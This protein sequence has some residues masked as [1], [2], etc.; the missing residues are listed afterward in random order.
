MSSHQGRGSNSTS[1][2]QM[3]L[4]VDGPAL[5][6]SSPCHCPLCH[7]PCCLKDS[8]R[9]H[10]RQMPSCQWRGWRL[11]G[12]LGLINKNV[13]KGKEAWGLFYKEDGLSPRKGRSLAGE[14]GGEAKRKPCTVPDVSWRVL[15]LI[16]HKAPRQI[17][18]PDEQDVGMPVSFETRSCQNT[19]QLS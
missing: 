10:I 4:A 15:C 3:P 19:S 2:W 9:C 16:L 14:G 17:N 13:S 11:H 1:S 18:V 7:L 6:R 8:W 5:H 12:A